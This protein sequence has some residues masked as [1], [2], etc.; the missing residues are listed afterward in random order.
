MLPNEEIGPLVVV[1]GAHGALPEA[2]EAGEVGAEV[3]V[4][5]GDLGL[6]RARE[7]DGAEG[8]PP[9][10]TEHTKVRRIEARQAVGDGPAGA[11][12]ISRRTGREGEQ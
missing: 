8:P 12:F 7:H 1:E 10:A 2:G 9:S 5:E 4:L 11:W 6:R 3:V